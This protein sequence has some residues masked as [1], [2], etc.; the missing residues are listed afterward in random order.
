M[1]LPRNAANLSLIV[2][3]YFI[4]FGSRSL[5]GKNLHNLMSVKNPEYMHG[6][7]QTY[8]MNMHLF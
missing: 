2:L 3:F 1:M 4:L 5:L 7:M 6:W 8:W